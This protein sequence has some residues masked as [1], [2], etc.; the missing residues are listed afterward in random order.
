MIATVDASL[1][2]VGFGVLLTAGLGCIAYFFKKWADNIGTQIEKLDGKVEKV[3]SKV[4]D[5]VNAVGQLQVAAG[6]PPNLRVGRG[7]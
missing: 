1:I 7:R 5:A 3:D 2:P 6:W 4:D